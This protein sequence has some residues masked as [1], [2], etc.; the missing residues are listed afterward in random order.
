[1]SKEKIRFL[2]FALVWRMLLVVLGVF[3]VDLAALAAVTISSVQGKV[4]TDTKD[5]AKMISDVALV[6]G[7]GFV[8]A[9]FFKFHQHKLNPTQ[10]PL[11][12]GLTLLIIGAGLSIFPAI[13]TGASK[14]V[15]GTS[16]AGS[17][18]AIIGS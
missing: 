10:V 15:L 16:T 5:L 17:I 9:S 8:L 6:T 3:C 18:T 7:I 1:M 14:S 2:S 12:Q 4:A 11:S 13:I